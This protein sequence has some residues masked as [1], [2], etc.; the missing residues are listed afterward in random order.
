[1]LVYDSDIVHSCPEIANGSINLEHAYGLTPLTFEWSDGST[2]VTTQ[3]FGSRHIFGNGYR[4]IMDVLPKG[5][6]LSKK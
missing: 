1:M 2:E 5:A 3:R 6:L 4:W